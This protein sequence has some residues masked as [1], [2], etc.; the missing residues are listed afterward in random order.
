MKSHGNSALG[1]RSDG[2]ENAMSAAA[3]PEV[4]PTDETNNARTPDLPVAV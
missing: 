2:R 3:E 1:E 4:Q